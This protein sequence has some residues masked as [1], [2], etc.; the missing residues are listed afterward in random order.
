MSKK[1]I[2]V[3]GVVII[4]NDEVL[5]VHDLEGSQNKLGRS[6]LPAGRVEKD[7]TN[8]EAAA[9]ELLEE[10]GLIAE[11]LKE[12]PE[13]YV[14]ELERK[15]GKKVLM[16]WIV[17]LGLKYSGKLKSSKESKPEWVKIDDLQNLHLRPN[18]ENAINQALNN[19]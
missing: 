11:K 13:K 4:R 7:E 3:S 8:E 1:A 6:G 19:L 15:S 14:A 12:L 16:S 9:R 10:T 5:L 17:Y 18:T 2:P